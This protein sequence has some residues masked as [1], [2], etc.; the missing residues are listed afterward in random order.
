MPVLVVVIL[1][2]LGS[3]YSFF[4]KTSLAR[5]ALIATAITVVLTAFAI[6]KASVVAIVAGI[7]AATPAIL[8][9]VCSWFVPY[10]LDDCIS[11]RIAAELAFAVYRWQHN[12]VLSAATRA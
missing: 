2:A 10:N 11:A 7:A 9:T 5:Y 4:R 6:V 1:N 12:I 8:G 3:L